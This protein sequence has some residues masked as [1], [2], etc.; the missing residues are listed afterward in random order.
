MTSH[1]DHTLQR[2]HALVSA[3]RA[4]GIEVNDRNVVDLVL[5]NMGEFHNCDEAV[6]A[7]RAAGFQCRVSTGNAKVIL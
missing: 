2:I 5:D 3:C 4:D 6:K 1:E 7:I